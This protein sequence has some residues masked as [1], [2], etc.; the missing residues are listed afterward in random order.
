MIAYVND[1]KSIKCG[2][3][4]GQLSDWFWL[5]QPRKYGT[6]MWD[7]NG[8]QE[9]CDECVGKFCPTIIDE[10]GVI[11]RYGT[12]YVFYNRAIYDNYTRRYVDWRHMRPEKI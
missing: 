4:R 11:N 5:I 2:E 12:K 6:L 7:S 8:F 3:C 9:T 1:G 10:L